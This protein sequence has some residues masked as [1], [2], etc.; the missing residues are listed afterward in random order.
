MR[1]SVVGGLSLALAVGAI[2]V[3]VLASGTSATYTDNV[4]NGVSC[5]SGTACVAVGSHTT[6]RFDI[7]TLSEAWNGTAWRLL[8]TPSPT[9]TTDS[10]LAGVSCNSPNACI[11]V[12]SSGDKTLAEAWDGTSWRIL[13]TPNPAL[14]GGGLAM[15]G[16]TGVTMLSPTN[17][18][19]VGFRSITSGRPSD[20]LIEHW[21]GRRWSVVKSPNAVAAT[22]AGTKFNNLGGVSCSSARVCIAIGSWGT[23][24][25]RSKT[26]A[27]TWNGTAWR[28]AA[29]PS[30]TAGG[31]DLL[32]GVSA[33]SSND[34]WAVGGRRQTPD[35]VTKT[36]IEHW[37]GRR[38]MVS[39]SP[40]P[41]VAGNELNAVV[42]VSAR[43]V[44]AVG[45]IGL[46]NRVQP[47]AVHWNGARWARVSTPKP[48]GYSSLSGVARVPATPELWAV[49][50]TALPASPQSSVA[51]PLV[52]H[53][54]GTGWTVTPTPA[55]PG[56]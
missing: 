51:V 3:P 42:A 22:A 43:N 36:L 15:D 5:S 45:T 30:P 35:G 49:G 21:N 16:L 20:T 41:L 29:T 13:P 31:G 8:R 38:W 25:T 4:L 39:T 2:S 10:E 52:E 34:A 50:A 48:I 24:L 54:S 47:L 37:N 11:A 18:W 27:E 33:L 14:P 53:W 32:S 9:G 44:W 19:A 1:K 7:K 55:V 26:L 46:D 23:S 17:A 40:N 12:G 56:G 28:V 6:P